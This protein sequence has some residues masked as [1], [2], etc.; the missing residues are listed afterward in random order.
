MKGP[1]GN[2]VTFIADQRVKR[3][4]EIKVGD[5][6]KADYYVSVAAE[7]RQPTAEEEKFRSSCW[8]R[9][10]RPSQRRTRGG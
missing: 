4:N 10:P 9:R 7:L 3:L 1:L 2:S 6:I 5:L 8:T